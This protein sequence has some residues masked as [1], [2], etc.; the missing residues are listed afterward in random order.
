M[1][2]AAAGLL[3]RLLVGAGR[4]AVPSEMSS[5]AIHYDALYRFASF[6]VV[7]GYRCGSHFLKLLFQQT[8]VTV[9][10]AD[11]G[12]EATNHIG[13]VDLGFETTYQFGGI[14]PDWTRVHAK[15]R[16]DSF[17]AQPI[18]GMLPVCFGLRWF[19]ATCC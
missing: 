9:K 7:A 13:G 3:P 5:G 12:F 16:P 8:D 14:A 18:H 10:F 15:V 11:L 1:F 19:V 4:S 6:S 17:E 2:A